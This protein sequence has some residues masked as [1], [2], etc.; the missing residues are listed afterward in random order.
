MAEAARTEAESAASR[1]EQM[2]HDRIASAE[3][4]AVTEVRLAAA[5][6][7]ARAAEQIIAHTLTPEADAGIIDR[8][9]T[10]LPSALA[11]RRAA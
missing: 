9:I 7:A 5:D 6:I 2:A 8:A 3:K 4:A 1:R 11:S 10:G